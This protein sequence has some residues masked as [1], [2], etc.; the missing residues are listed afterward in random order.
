[1][2]QRLEQQAAIAEHQ[3]ARDSLSNSSASLYPIGCT[4]WDIEPLNGRR[5]LGAVVV[6]ADETKVI[7]VIVDPNDRHPDSW[8][9]VVV[10]DD[11]ARAMLRYHLFRWMTRRDAYSMT[12][13]VGEWMP[14]KL[15]AHRMATLSEAQDEVGQA[16][17]V[18]KGAIR[19]SW[20]GRLFGLSR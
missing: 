18:L 12:E 1:M 20:I 5:R 17:D 19:G 10:D 11:E 16:V 15:T 4:L 8:P 7:S 6:S 3:R 9:R 14:V 13:H 2:M